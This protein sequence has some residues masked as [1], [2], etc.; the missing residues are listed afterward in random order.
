MKTIILNQPGQ[1]CFTE[2]LLSSQPV[3]KRAVGRVRRIGICGTDLHAFRGEQPFFTYPR[4]LGHELAIEIVGVGENAEGLR[5]GD[6]CAVEP[7]LNCGECIA[8]R[9]GKTN[10]CER[11]QVLGVHADGGMREMLT[12]PTNKLHTSELLALDQLALVE[13]L[14]IG[15]HAVARS[16]IAAGEFALV[17]GA[18]PIGLSVI[19]F[20]QLSGGRVIAMDINPDRLKFAREHF[21]IEAAIEAG[22]GAAR[23]IKEITGGDLPTVV[24]D[25][26]G[27]PRS[28]QEC[29]HLI[30]H[31][32][33]LVF[34]G[35]F[36]GDVTFNDPEAHRRELTLLCSR[37]AV[38]ADFKRVVSLL[39]S[40]AIDIAPWITHR[41]AFGE[42]V[43]REFPRWLDPQSQ[44]VKA[45]IEL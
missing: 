25:A 31:G 30:A 20:A 22:V 42:E 24:F 27:N 12:V 33:R 10:C 3:A 40:S 14:S 41:V 19:Q 8:C 2:G 28:M 35:L 17:V 15:A 7:Y 6:R 44:F 39:E 26:T 38:G 37:N 45:V 13:P 21:V 23:Q 4:V 9:N 34:V 36:Q 16:D 32:G 1:L 29:F 18:G 5:V 43:I 11:I